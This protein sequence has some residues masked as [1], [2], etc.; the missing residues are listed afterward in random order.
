MFRVAGLDNFIVAKNSTELRLAKK[1][2]LCGYII[3]EN[4]ST[5]VLY[6]RKL[7]KWVREDYHFFNEQIIDDFE[8][9]GLKAYQS[10]YSYCGKDNIERMKK[11]IPNIDVW[12]S[13]EQLHYAN[14]LHIK[15]KIYKDIYVFDVNSSFTYGVLQLPKEFDLLKEY[16]IELYEKKKNASSKIT[17]QKYK[18][19][20]NFLIG[21]F[22]R[23]KEFISL[24][25][26]IIKNSNKNIIDKIVEIKES[27]GEVYIS[28]TDSIIT[29]SVGASVMQKYIGNEIGQFKL[30]LYSNRLYYNSSNSYQ[31]G[32][33]LV[34]S[35]LQYFARKH[36]DIFEEKYA[37]QY[38]NL[39]EQY[40]FLLS[41]DENF[42]KICRIRFGE[43]IV[44][45][46]NKLGEVI[47]KYSYRIGDN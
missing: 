3:M 32:D 11:V 29:D 4:K 30:E 17:R 19:L 34:W 28:N 13:E 24:R 16:M 43:I 12:D 21:Y 9:T 42:R 45:V 44:I 23:I 22:A 15:E 20:Q 18:N 26:Q 5:I 27:G 25:S 36:T 1:C 37:K 40:D 41:E 35:G 47:K 31:I 8:T 46:E 10:F 39:I 14:I 6:T 38:G 7:N 33:K 2:E